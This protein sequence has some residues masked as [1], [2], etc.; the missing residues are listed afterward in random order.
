[1]LHW[2][3]VWRHQ[4]PVLVENMATRRVWGVHVPT[5]CE[6][7]RE[8][9]VTRC[10]VKDRRTRTDDGKAMTSLIY[11]RP[12][13]PVKSYTCAQTKY[14]HVTLAKYNCIL[15]VFF[16]CTRNKYFAI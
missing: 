11:C 12:P 9:G 13:S 16:T 8:S 3:P 14:K 15:T 6:T 5:I 4:E 1:M 10:S 2:F 7:K